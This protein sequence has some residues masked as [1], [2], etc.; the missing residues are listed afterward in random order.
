M[1]CATVVFFSKPHKDY[2][3][4]M[5]QNIIFN[6]YSTKH[7][8]IHQLYD[9]RRIS[10]I[11]LYVGLLACMLEFKIPRNWAVLGVFILNLYLFKDMMA[12]RVN[13]YGVDT[14]AY[15]VQGGQFASG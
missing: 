3:R 6:D 13:R 14:T 12:V 5:D 2:D 15:I 7:N 9:N 1:R 4:L 11:L 8:S 10:E